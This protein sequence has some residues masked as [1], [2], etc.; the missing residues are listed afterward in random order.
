MTDADAKSNFTQSLMWR[1][2]KETNELE[3][4]EI[5]ADTTADALFDTF[6]SYKAFLAKAKET[7]T[8]LEKADGIHAPA[9]DASEPSSSSSGAASLS[10]ARESDS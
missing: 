4:T 1:F 9:P 7:L 8:K 2:Y 3:R 6:A 10:G 5:K